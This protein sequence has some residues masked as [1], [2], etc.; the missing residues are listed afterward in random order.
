MNIT[1]RAHILENKPE[2]TNVEKGV[3]RA[4]VAEGTKRLKTTRY[5]INKLQG[6]IVQHREYS[7]YFL[8]ILMECNL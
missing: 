3:G 2:V 6:Y 5:N 4:R 1:K 7:Q 8:I